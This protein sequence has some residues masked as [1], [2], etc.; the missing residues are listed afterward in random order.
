[1]RHGT[2]VLLATAVGAAIFA[3]GISGS[4]GESSHTGALAVIAVIVALL[5]WNATKPAGSSK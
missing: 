2:R 1:M 4:G 3:F 5:V